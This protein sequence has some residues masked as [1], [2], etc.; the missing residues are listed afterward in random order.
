MYEVSKCAAQEAL[1]DLDDAF[2]HFFRRCKLKKQ[3]KFKGKVGYP[4]RKNKKK[5]VGGFAITGTIKVFSDR[6]QLPRVG[7]VRLKERNYLPTDAHI[8]RTTVTEQA[9]RWF[10]SV[11]VDLKINN[12]LPI[13]PQAMA[14]VDLG[15]SAMA[16]CRDGVIENPKALRKNLKKLCR[17]S[18]HVSRKVKG[19]KNRKKAARRLAKLHRRIANIRKDATHQATSYLSKT[20]TVVVLE[21][22]NVSGM[23]KNHRM[24]RAIA[25]VG[26][27]E[28]RRQMTYKCAWYGTELFFVS[29]WFPSTKRCSKCHHVQP[30]PL[31]IDTFVCECCDN[32]LPRDVNAFINLEQEYTASSAGIHACGELSADAADGWRETRLAETGNEQESRSPGFSQ[33]S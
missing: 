17:R 23:L 24:A 11:Q 6:I 25:D 31:G 10:V 15:V 19:S 22:L 26:L 20:K 28:F 21:D 29:Q 3:G 5:G 8:I 12:D 33:V 9:D 18:R 4:K 32:V 30:M 16:T 2:K 27:F 7:T 13:M 1:V 14:G